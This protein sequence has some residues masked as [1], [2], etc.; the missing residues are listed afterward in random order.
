MGLYGNF[1]SSFSITT[2]LPSIS[3]SIVVKSSLL[4]LRIAKESKQTLLNLCSL[5]ISKHKPLV[6][7]DYLPS[8][9][10]SKAWLSFAIIS[11]TSLVLDKHC[12]IARAEWTAIAHWAKFMPARA[13]A[14]EQNLHTNS[15]ER[16]PLTSNDIH[17]A[18]LGKFY[19]VFYLA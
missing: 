14:F 1:S 18:E 16:I 9:W 15:P 13:L 10:L 12:T 6:Y 17:F 3:L 11:L 19:D 4:G 7:N 2:I 5:H 8:I